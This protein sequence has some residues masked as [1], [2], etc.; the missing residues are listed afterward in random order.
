M[1]LLMP[2]ARLFSFGDKELLSRADGKL[3]PVPCFG[4]ITLN[5]LPFNLASVARLR[6]FIK[7]VLFVVLSLDERGIYVAS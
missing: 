4:F 6:L 3:N 1:R 5:V 7:T 2:M